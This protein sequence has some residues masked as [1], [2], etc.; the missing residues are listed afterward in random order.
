MCQ[1][2]TPISGFPIRYATVIKDVDLKRCILSCGLHNLE[3]GALSCR[4]ISAKRKTLI[5]C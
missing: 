3:Y 4:I 5:Q 2:L 1:A